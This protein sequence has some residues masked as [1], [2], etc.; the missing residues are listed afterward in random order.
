MAKVANLAIL[1]LFTGD[2]TKNKY[3]TRANT[4]RTTIEPAHQKNMLTFSF[5]IIFKLKFHKKNFD[6]FM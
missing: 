4:A 5:Y 6:F 2:T 3:R 1:S